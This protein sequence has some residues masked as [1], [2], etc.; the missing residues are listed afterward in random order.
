MTYRLTFLFSCFI[1]AFGAGL[2]AGCS[3]DFDTEEE[4]TFVCDDDGD[5]TGNFECV[6]GYCSFPGGNGEE[7][8]D[9]NN[10]QP[11]ECIPEQLEVYP[12]D[13]PLDIPERCDGTDN[14]CDG[15][16]D[17][18]VCESSSDCP[19]ERDPNDT[20]LTGSCGDDGVCEYSAPD[21]F[22]CPDPIECIDGEFEVVPSECT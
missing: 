18:L 19:T 7:D 9:S 15:Q 22:I 6:D 13:P 2:F 4:G 11:D 8:A 21:T 10:G 3:V 12:L 14:N 1:V 17:V 20:R 16:V 5:C